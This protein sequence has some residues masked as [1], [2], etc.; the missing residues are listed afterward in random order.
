MKK[1]YFRKLTFVILALVSMVGCERSRLEVKEEPVEPSEYYWSEDNRP[2]VKK[3]NLAEE[4]EALRLARRERGLDREKPNVLWIYIEDMNPFLGCYGTT[5]IDTPNMDRLAKCGV[6]FNRAFVTAPVCSPCRSAIIT[7]VMQTTIGTHNH[8]SSYETAPVHLP[9]HV[10]TVPEIFKEHGYY[11]FN[12][13]KDN[14]NFVFDRDKL[15]EKPKAKFAPWR[16]APQGKPFFGQIQ[17]QGG[18]QIFFPET[19]DARKVRVEPADASETIPPYYPDHPVIRNRWAEHYDCVKMTDDEVGQIVAN[20]EADGLLEN[21]IIVCFSDHG[22]HLPRHKQF[23]YE[24]GLQVPLI[25]SCLGENKLIPQDIKRD[26]LVSGLDI[27]ASTLGLAEIP[28]PE[29]YDGRNLFADDHQPRD[30]VI[31]ARD[32]CDYTIDR[33]RSLRTKDGLKYIRNFMTDRPWT[34]PQ[35]RDGRDYMEVPRKMNA[36]G[37]L[38]EV[39]ARFWRQ[40]RPSEEL[41]DLNEDPYELH[42]LVDDKSYEPQL[43]A[44]RKQL[45]EW[46]EETNDQ[47]AIPESD[48]SL[49]AVYRLWGEKCVNPEFEGAKRLFQQQEKDKMTK[50]L[51]D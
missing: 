12:M 25:V 38:N 16:S 32:R 15:Y 46:I 3:F 49:L 45:A 2:L 39:Q 1:S 35:Y 23:C 30:F 34:Q 22:C 13:G 26:D 4:A 27:P 36:E 51:V 20:L 31:A 48:E 7:G 5:L 11:T 6:Q 40:E 29:W 37:E 47:G 33:I 42:N 8:V 44:L 9:E 18:K 28:I 50:E 14:Y 43:V 10:R 19:F 41:Y 21:T 17:L 24:G